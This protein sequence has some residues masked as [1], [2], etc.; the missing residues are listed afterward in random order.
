MWTRR[1]RLHEVILAEQTHILAATIQLFPVGLDVLYAVD[2][3]GAIDNSNE[4]QFWTSTQ[5]VNCENRNAMEGIVL[6][7]TKYFTRRQAWSSNAFTTG[8][9]QNDGL[10]R[11]LQISML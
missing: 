5:W 10:P 4:A 2:Y 1:W 9:I 11:I 8:G 6:M 3:T 7:N